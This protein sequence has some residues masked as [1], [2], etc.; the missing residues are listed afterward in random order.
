MFAVSSPFSLSMIPV[1]RISAIR[2]PPL[3]KRT[4]GNEIS[5]ETKEGRE[6][7]METRR[8]EEGRIATHF[9]ARSWQ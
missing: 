4:G 2:A 7:E 3:Q 9:R 8:E 1:P 6:E 5:D